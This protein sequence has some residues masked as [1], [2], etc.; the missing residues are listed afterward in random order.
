MTLTLNSDSL[1]TLQQLCVLT[2]WQSQPAGGDPQAAAAGP[3]KGTSTKMYSHEYFGADNVH[4]TG[5]TE[6]K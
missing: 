1:S 4:V 3:Q 6:E 5:I 2:N